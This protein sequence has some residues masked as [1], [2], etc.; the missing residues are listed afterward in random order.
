V[1]PARSGAFEELSGGIEQVEAFVGDTV[2]AGKRTGYRGRELKRRLE[3]VHEDQTFGAG[4]ERVGSER[5]RSEYV[6]HDSDTVD[7]VAAIVGD[8]LELHDESLAPRR[9][10]W[11]PSAKRALANP[12]LHRRRGA[13]IGASPRTGRATVRLID[14]D[15]GEGGGMDLALLPRGVNFWTK[16]GFVPVRVVEEET[17]RRP[18]WLMEWRR[19]GS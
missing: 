15:S 17:E 12:H 6:N 13:H 8:E 14:E 10:G 7:P 3:V 4:V 18:F 16:V 19:A 9:W 5:E 2:L 1:R 11:A